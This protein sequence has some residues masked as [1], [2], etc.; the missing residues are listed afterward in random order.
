V[1]PDS[2]K[3]KLFQASSIA[4]AVWNSNWVGTPVS[5]QR[6][7]VLINAAANKT[8]ILTAGKFVPVSNKTMVNVRKL[9]A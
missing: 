9:L 3:C 8:F 4:D 6:C 5:F 7:L 1:K 2:N